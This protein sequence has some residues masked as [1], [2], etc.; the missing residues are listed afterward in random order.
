M[1]SFK[2]SCLRSHSAAEVEVQGT[3]SQRRGWHFAQGSINMNLGSS[4]LHYF[5]RENVTKNE[6]ESFILYVMNAEIIEGL[7]GRKL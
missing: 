6:N 4:I 5:L 7:E 2:I 3:F 1:G